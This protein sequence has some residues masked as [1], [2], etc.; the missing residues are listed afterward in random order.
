[1]TTINGASVVEQQL[2]DHVIAHGRDEGEILAAYERM[3]ED[4]DSP[5]FAFLA[6]LILDDE[7]K[8]HQ[9]LDALAT[10]IRTSA[11]LTGE[12]VPIPHLGGSSTA[13]RERILAET[14]RLLDFEEEDNRDLE[15]LAKQLKDVRNTTLWE[16]VVRIMQHDNEKHRRILQFIRDR[17]GDSI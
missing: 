9:L 12:P 11:E 1:M 6:Q 14:E 3:A 8:H 17:A 13:D 10:T 4:T 15:R 7:R 2:Y 16:L 5:A